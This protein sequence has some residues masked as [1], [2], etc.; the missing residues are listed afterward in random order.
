MLGLSNIFQVILMINPV[1]NQQDDN[2]CNF[3]AEAQSLSQ[4][5]LDSNATTP[6]LPQVWEAALFAMK[7][8]F[9]NPSSSHNTGVQAKQVVDEARRRAIQIIGA[10]KGDVIFTSGAT[11]VIQTAILSALISAK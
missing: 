9:G 4:I 1:E 7:T 2:N 11:E 3:M 6:V 5:Y 10:G 8:L